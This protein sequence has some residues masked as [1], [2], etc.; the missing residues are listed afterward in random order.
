M[1]T[2]TA[3]SLQAPSD[4]QPDHRPRGYDPAA[5]IDRYINAVSRA[6]L[7]L[8]LAVYSLRD[9]SARHPETARVFENAL[10]ALR[11]LSTATPRAQ[12]DGWSEC[13]ECLSPVRDDYRRCVFCGAAAPL[14][15]LTEDALLELV[16]EDLETEAG[17]DGIGAYE[18]WGSP[19]TDRRP[20]CE[21]V[22]GLVEVDVTGY[23][24]ADD[25]LPT[26]VTGS[27]DHEGTAYPFIL[28]FRCTK[29]QNGRVQAV[30]AVEGGRL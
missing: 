19:G 30:Y 26:Y 22:D 4:P 18:F 2:A 17:D 10:A 13:R 25:D 16:A 20:Y 12:L 9:H 14:P 15:A 11:E 24:H 21:I 7:P 27:K 28:H 5:V 1:I 23:A 3:P 29:A 6:K 8:A